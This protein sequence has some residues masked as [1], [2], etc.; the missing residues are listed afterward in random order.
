MPKDQETPKVTGNS[1][2]I[3]R[4]DIDAPAILKEDGTLIRPPVISSQAE[5]RPFEVYL[6]DPNNDLS[7][8]YL[9]RKSNTLS[10]E[11]SSI[12]EDPDV[13]KNFI[14]ML[15]S[16][17][18]SDE[19]IKTEMQGGE[20]NPWIDPV[21][22]FSGSLGAGVILSKTIGKPLLNALITSLAEYPVGTVTE[23]AGEKYPYLALP[24]NL[25][26]G[27][28]SGM[29]V[30]SKLQK[31]I[32]N[33][34]EKIKA[35]VN[36]KSIQQL[37]NELS[38]HVKTKIGEERGS[39]SNKPVSPY[40]STSP[41]EEILQDFSNQIQEEV[42]G[43][44]GRI[45]PS[46]KNILINPDPASP[47]K[48]DMFFKADIEDLTSKA[49]NI[50]FKNI[51]S[52]DDIKKI[53]NQTAVAYGDEI[54][55]AQR[56]VLSNEETA[57]L[58]EN[59]GLDVGQLLSRRQGQAFNAE[60][61]YAARNLLVSSAENLRNSAQ[62]AVSPD[63]SDLDK[64]EFRKLLN[65]HFAIQSEVSGMT[66]EA[67]RA[68]QQFKMP[69]KSQE[70]L[71]RDIKG[72]MDYLKG[73]EKDE[74]T[75]TL[76]SAILTLDEVGKLTRF[77]DKANKSGSMNMLVEYWINSILSGPMT[78]M[79]NMTSNTLTALWQIPERALAAGIGKGFEAIG[80]GQA[81]I[82]LEEAFH[83]MLGIKNGFE[84]GLKL[85]AKTTE[86]A[87]DE[88]LFPALSQLLKTF[89]DSKGK[90]E[91]A[92]AITGGNVL[93]TGLG[94]MIDQAGYGGPLARAADLLGEAVRIPGTALQAEDAVFKAIGYRMELSAQ[95]FRRAR[96]EG[97]E[98]EALTQRIASILNDPPDDLV[99]LAKDNADYLT[100]TKKLGE[101]GTK[102]SSLL[103]A[104]PAFRFV[105][106]FVKT[107]TNIFKFFG[108]RTPLALAS[109]AVRDD[110][111]EGGAVRDLA[112]ARMALGSTVM[113]LVGWQ[114]LE[115]NITGAGPKD[116]ALQATWRRTG[117][118]PYSFKF[119]DTYYSYQRMEP[120]GTLIGVAADIGEIYSQYQTGAIQDDNA[121]LYAGLTALSK[122]VSNKTFLQGLTNFIETQSD[123][124]RYLPSYAKRMASSFIPNISGQVTSYEVD[125]VIRQTR[126]MI[127]AFKAKIPGLSD[128][129]PPRRN[130]WGEPVEREGG[131]IPGIPDLVNPLFISSDKN[132]QLDELMKKLNLGI[133]PPEKFINGVELL[134]EEYDRFSFLAGNG[135]KNPTTG[136]G[137]KDTLSE[138]INDP[139]FQNLTDEKEGGK[140]RAIKKYVEAFRDAAKAQLLKENPE[141]AN[142]IQQHYLDKQRKLTG[143]APTFK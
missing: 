83:L 57:K 12:I 92:P 18:F 13:T 34:L 19:Q 135:L 103:N 119:G 114:A 108:E 78:H 125:P 90:I 61:A 97:L 10:P 81:E 8:S 137:L 60:Q 26:M 47:E 67:G 68:L 89:T 140:A 46:D 48:T 99:L 1:D 127:D 41:S 86:I 22:A 44:L 37:A 33:Y 51:E 29:T 110:I 31:S 54:Q 111:S 100:Y 136:L 79:V 75:N 74:T 49:I 121:L 2:S 91:I 101:V 21:S 128:T 39:F 52:T 17:G 80:K 66:A 102:F 9:E 87:K 63:A 15:K 96:S 65:L 64:F 95:A 45:A 117:W 76:A 62:R 116:A 42:S 5:E 59:L 77:V 14:N 129:L 23:V 73:L 43:K 7:G 130:L 28:V 118:Q 141:L 58:A 32:V 112:L 105:I 71:V 107:P 40:A 70:G 3:P 98:G 132:S 131:G 69:A 16:K 122:N 109:K 82:G 113:A 55:A 38:D 11:A 24:F 6:V 94:K 126:T 120:L 115:G 123:P 30:E 124:Q 4:I 27:V 85:I 36:R 53:I 84:D 139:S 104:H 106:P 50:N 93:Q 133:A 56:G 142:V 72:S 138:L 20:T 25:A 134:P 35:P 143:G 88:K